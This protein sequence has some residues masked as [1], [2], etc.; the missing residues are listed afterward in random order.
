MAECVVHLNSTV[1]KRGQYTRTPAIR[2]YVG[3][4]PWNSSAV[5]CSAARRRRSGRGCTVASVTCLART[6]NHLTCGWSMIR[7]DRRLLGQGVDVGNRDRQR[8]RRPPDRIARCPGCSPG[9][10][11]RGALIG[12]TSATI[13]AGKLFAGRNGATVYRLKTER[14]HRR[15]IPG[16]VSPASA[17]GVRRP[18]L[19]GHW[20]RPDAG[21]VRGVF[22]WTAMQ[23][24]QRRQR[25]HPC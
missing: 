12:A 21:R 14:K 24:R 16:I 22:H 8:R 18:Q 7:G 13:T 1:R 2:S 10:R 20:L 5:R 23:V 6:P 17:I 25:G 4:R 3:A 19:W 9:Y 11:D 15:R